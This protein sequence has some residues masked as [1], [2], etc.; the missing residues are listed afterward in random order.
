MPLTTEIFNTINVNI[1]GTTWPE[2]QKNIFYK[3]IEFLQEQLWK[4]IKYYLYYTF[5][6]PVTNEN[7]HNL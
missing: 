1:N 2:K 7:A 5:L 4:K 3:I 6:L